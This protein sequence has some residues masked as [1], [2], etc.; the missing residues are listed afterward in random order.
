MKLKL[1][2]SKS[3]PRIY[4]NIKLTRCLIK[5]TIPAQIEVTIMDTYLKSNNK[6]VK[7]IIYGKE[8]F[9]YNMVNN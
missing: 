4:P 1:G 2:Y 3:K 7:I 9:S 6:S 8:K 5:N